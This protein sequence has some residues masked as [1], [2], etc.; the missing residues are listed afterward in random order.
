MARHVVQTSA[1]GAAVALPGVLPDGA[2]LLFVGSALFGAGRGPS[3]RER[4]NSGHGLLGPD[5]LLRPFAPLAARS[6]R[7][8]SRGPC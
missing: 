5:A 6:V 2:K 8:M 4:A 1:E 3:I 7:T